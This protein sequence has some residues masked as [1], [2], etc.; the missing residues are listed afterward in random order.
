MKYSTI[1]QAFTFSF[2]HQK[3]KDNKKKDCRLRSGAKKSSYFPKRKELATLKRASALAAGAF[4]F[5]VRTKKRNKE[6]RRLRS[7]AKK[8]SYFP[9]RKELATLKQ[10]FVLNGKY[11]IFLHA[12]PLRPEKPSQGGH[13]ASL[14]NLFL[15]HPDHTLTTNKKKNIKTKTSRLGSFP[16]RDE[17]EMDGR[18]TLI[19]KA[20]YP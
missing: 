18:C 15:C 5:F 4:H 10:L 20:E 17:E 13:I 6:K 19:Q 12:P 11:S 3:E 1:K 8:S 2:C 16:G 9:K 7:G 14:V